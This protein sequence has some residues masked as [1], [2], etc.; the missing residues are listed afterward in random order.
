MVEEV[1]LSYSL[2]VQDLADDSHTVTYENVTK[3]R[4]KI[5]I[6][7]CYSIELY[8]SNEAGTSAPSILSSPP[9][10]PANE[11]SAESLASTSLSRTSG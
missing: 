8:A 1:P 9:C 11:T 10:S 2:V 7:E 6:P 4:I 5:D 3:Q